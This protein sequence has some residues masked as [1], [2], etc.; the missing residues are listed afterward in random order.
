MFESGEELDDVK[1]ETWTRSENK[2]YEPG[3]GASGM[4]GISGR[5]SG[6]AGEGDATDDTTVPPASV[7]TEGEFVEACRVPVPECCPTREFSYS[8]I[9]AASAD[10]LP[11]LNMLVRRV[12]NGEG[13]KK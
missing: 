9:L 7:S 4:P 13:E 5:L 6:W 1:Y 8:S 11:L 3:E 10:L 12:V 2:I